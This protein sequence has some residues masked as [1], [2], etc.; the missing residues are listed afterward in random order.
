MVSL[1]RPFCVAPA[2]VSFGLSP[3]NG[4][5]IAAATRVFLQEANVTSPKRGRRMIRPAAFSVEESALTREDLVHASGHIG[6]PLAAAALNFSAAPADVADFP[7]LHHAPRPIDV[8]L[9]QLGLKARPEIAPLG[10]PLVV[11]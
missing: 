9:E 2:K 1:A 7:Q 6:Q 11:L 5:S 4:R 3:A 8:A 10:R